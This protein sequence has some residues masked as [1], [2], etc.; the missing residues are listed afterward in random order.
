MA[1]QVQL[2]VTI[3]VPD[4]VPLNTPAMETVIRQSINDSEDMQQLL[5]R[6]LY[7]TTVTYETD[8]PIE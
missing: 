2:V 4:D 5:H 3:T 1:R 7:I 6:S 8:Y